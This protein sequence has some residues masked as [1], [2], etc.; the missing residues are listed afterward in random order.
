MSFDGLFTREMIFELRKT[1]E[2]G[3]I[4]KIHQPSKNE[5]VMIV[6]AQGKNHKVLLSAHPS[7]ARAHLTNEDFENPTTPPM[8]CMLLRKH[9]EGSVIEKVEQHGLDR[10]IV[11]DVIGRDEI[12]DVSIKQLMI[13]I[14]GRHSN[15]VLIQKDK[16]TI[17]DCIKHVPMALNSYRTLLPGAPYIFP[18][19]QDKVNPFESTKEVVLHKIDFN[20]GKLDKQLTQSFLGFSP[21]VSKEIVHQSGLANRE[22]LPTSFLNM[23]EKLRDHQIKPAM[24]EGEKLSFYLFPLEHLGGAIKSFDTLGELLD[25][26]YFGKATRDRVKQQANDLERL[27]K[28]EKD[29][30]DLK[31]IKLQQSLQDAEDASKYQLF[32]ELLTANLHLLHKGFELAE[33][34]NYYDENQSTVTI[35]LNKQK[36]PSENA[37][38]YFTKYQKSKTAKIAIAEQLELTKTEILYFESLLQQLETA[39]TRDIEEIREELVEGKYL[40]SRVKDKNKKKKIKKLELE[41]YYATDGTQILVGKNNKQN[42]FLTNKTAAKDDVW[43]HTKDIPGS[44]VVIRHSSPNEQTINEAAILASFFSKA[45]DS[46]SVPVDFTKIRHVKKPS[47]AKPGFVTYDHQKT[48]FVTPNADLVIKMKNQPTI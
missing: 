12:G 11:F 20:A 34:V 36:S 24:I 43:L 14:M 21:L 7:Y 48:V 19:S 44:H 39:S 9:L 45:R 8:F 42:D 31:L 26:F 40:R 25:R 3:R 1:I 4:S 38:R 6:R 47:G 2:G 32:G 18:P 35:P 30:N 5:L 17:L 15:I 46:S 13:E 27:I 37:Q 22:T 16:R 28:N 23:I 41:M 33:V 10:M 29:K